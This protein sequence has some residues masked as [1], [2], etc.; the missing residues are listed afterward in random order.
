MST[1]PFG[2]LSFRHFDGNENDNRL[3]YSKTAVFVEKQFAFGVDPY[4]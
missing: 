2:Y 4:K 3:L 1:Y